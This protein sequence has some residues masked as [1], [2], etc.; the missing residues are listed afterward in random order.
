M[1]RTTI[2]IIQTCINRRFTNVIILLFLSMYDHFN[3]EKIGVILTLLSSV[4]AS[5][6]GQVLLIDLQLKK[7]VFSMP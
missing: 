7:Q 3:F 4:K 2:L 1:I 5:H 6:I